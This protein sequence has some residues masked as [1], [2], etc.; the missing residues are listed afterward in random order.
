MIWIQE[1]VLF[2][3]ESK[4]LL[5]FRAMLYPILVCSLNI[6]KSIFVIIHDFINWHA[7]PDYINREYFFNFTEIAP[8]FEILT[9]MK[10][11][12]IMHVI[13]DCIPKIFYWPYSFVIIY[14]SSNIIYNCVL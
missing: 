9:E 7:S 10:F 4:Q 8:I 5:K 6:I 1:Q 3:N 12:S 2:L 13:Y 11:F 14:N